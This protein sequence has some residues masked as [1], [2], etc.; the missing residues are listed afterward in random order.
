MS[1]WGAIIALLLLGAAGCRCGGGDGVASGGGQG[2]VA[3]GGEGALA[4][5][6]LAHVPADAGFLVASLEPLP[7]A[8]LDRV[9]PEVRRLAA[10]VAAELDEQGGDGPAT[11]VVIRKLSAEGG[12]ERLLGIER[13]AR[14]I[15][16]SMSGVIALRVEVRDEEVPRRTLALLAR[17]GG[18]LEERVHRNV[19]Y[20]WEDDR[21]LGVLA[22]VHAGSLVLAV[23]PRARL[24]EQLSRVLGIARPLT[25][26]RPE[27][28]RLR[29]QHQMRPEL[30]GLVRTRAIA[31]TAISG[32]PFDGWT[33]GNTI[34]GGCARAIEETLASA[35]HVVFSLEEATARRTR[36]GFTLAL[37]DDL[38]ARVR[39]A[40]TA[41]PGVGRTAGED[42]ALI[43]LGAAADLGALAALLLDAA[44]SVAQLLRA[45]GEREG[46]ESWEALP[47]GLAGADERFLQLRGF[48]VAILDGS[49]DHVEGHAL[50]AGPRLGWLLDLVQDQE[51][52]L[53]LRPIP[54]DGRF[55]LLL[56]DGAARHLE[57]DLRAA[58]ADGHLR[59]AIGPRGEA[60]VP[61]PPTGGPSPFWSASIDADALR[62]RDLYDEDAVT[63]AAALLG[64]HDISTVRLEPTELGLTVTYE[65]TDR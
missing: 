62:Q 11:A 41:V 50:V 53:P 4:D 20:W 36:L 47:A 58:V 19:R 5:A 6:L 59:L 9:A 55:H 57:G 35:P 17:P 37:R 61:P 8:Y 10:R 51:P 54:A 18:P 64:E 30:L 3:A 48:H 46:A 65:A 29:D 15:L 31:E 14:F 45:C 7:D 43:S 38:L 27:L 12:L 39:R 24:T 63:L 23:G 42:G 34:A 21:E 1:R 33:R 28:A 52:D 49:E 2:D 40:Q 60:F 32:E 56:A 25:D 16:H 22:A 44:P 26:I 13:T